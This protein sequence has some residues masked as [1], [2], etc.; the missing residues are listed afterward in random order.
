MVEAPFGAKAIK[1]NRFVNR[2]AEMWR[3]VRDWLAAGGAIPNDAALKADLST[4]RYEF[5]AAGRLKLES[6]DEIKARLGRSPDT[7]DAL[8]LTFYAPVPARGMVRAGV[9]TTRPAFNHWR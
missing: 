7:A 9:H 2:R 8:A 4:P 3:A 6:K 1:D 5:D